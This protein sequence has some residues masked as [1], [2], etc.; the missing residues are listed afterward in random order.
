MNL[1]LLLPERSIS[2]VGAYSLKD[3]IKLNLTFLTLPY[4]GAPPPL[5]TFLTLELTATGCSNSTSSSS[6]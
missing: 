4:A 3:P 5:I 2:P 6:S 1:N